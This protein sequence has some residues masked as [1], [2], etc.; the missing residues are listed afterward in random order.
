[1]EEAISYARRSGN[2]TLNDHRLFFLLLI[3]EDMKGL[4]GTGPINT[5]NR[6]LLE[7]SAPRLMH[8]TD[9]SI[10]KNLVLRHKAQ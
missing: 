5:D 10:A 4:F 1:M 3:S 2:I 7:F 6:P 9:L 8:T